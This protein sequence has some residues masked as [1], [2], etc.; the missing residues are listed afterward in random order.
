MSVVDVLLGRSAPLDQAEEE[1]GR[2]IK[3]EETDLVLHVTRCAERWKL[4]YRASK[5]NNAQL[6]Q[7]RLFLII[8][9]VIAACNSPPV[10]HW[11]ERL[12]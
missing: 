11:L 12:F 9:T 2:P 3:A 7:I 6:G 4:S 10:A 8:V 5:A 1:L